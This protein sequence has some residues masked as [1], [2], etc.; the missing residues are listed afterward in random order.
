MLD[1]NE[2]L[3][4]TC[5]KIEFSDLSITKMAVSIE[6]PNPIPYEMSVFEA[7]PDPLPLHIYTVLQQVCTHYLRLND[8]KRTSEFIKQFLAD[9]RDMISSEYRYLRDLDDSHKALF[10]FG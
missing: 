3:A 1:K 8:C 9:H 10:L 2:K 7:R 4:V 6:K 5:S